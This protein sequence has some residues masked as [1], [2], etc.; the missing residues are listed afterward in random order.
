MIHNSISYG[1]APSNTPT[2]TAF[3]TK[4]KGTISYAAKLEAQHPGYICH[5]FRYAQKIWGTLTTFAELA[6]EINEKSAIDSSPLP[7]TNFSR[8]QIQNWFKQQGGKERIP[9]T[10]PL[11]TPEYTAK[12]MRWVRKWYDILTN[13]EI[14]VAYLDKKWF[15]TTNRWRKMKQ[16]PR[17]G[18]KRK[19]LM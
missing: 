3:A 1:Q 5:L 14:P 19:A 10:K 15:Y 6:A 9:T 11:D 17:G 18:V 8:R 4:Q 12:R 7:T 13:K 2:A 16:R